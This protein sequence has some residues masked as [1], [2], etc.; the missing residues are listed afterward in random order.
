MKMATRR[1]R[2][3][4]PAIPARE[5]YDPG[6]KLDPAI[7]VFHSE[8]RPGAVLYD[9][10]GPGVKLTLTIEVGPDRHARPEYTLNLDLDET[11]LIRRSARR[12]RVMT[13]AL[14]IL[15]NVKIRRY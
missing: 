8:P 10:T 14:P 5:P 9:L 11:K 1:K 7:D 6:L 13:F 4:R 12:S 15:P 2:I 3:T